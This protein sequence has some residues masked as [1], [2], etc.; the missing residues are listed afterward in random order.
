MRSCKAHGIIDADI[1]V[2]CPECVVLLR[3]V[4]QAAHEEITFTYSHP[5][6]AERGKVWVERGE[7]PKLYKAMRAYWDALKASGKT[8]KKKP[9]K[10]P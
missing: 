10:K 8:V 6:A 4:A 3:S 2:G 7:V 5:L 9:R 1:A